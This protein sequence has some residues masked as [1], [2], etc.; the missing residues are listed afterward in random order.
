VLTKFGLREVAIKQFLEVLE[1]EVR[2]TQDSPVAEFES[3]LKKCLA[4]V[5]P[6]G[7]KDEALSERAR[8]IYDEIKELFTGDSL[9]DIGCGDG[10]ISVLA[11][12]HFRRTVATDVVDIVPTAF[13]NLGL[14]FKAYKEGSPLPTGDE[15][16]DTV[17]LL[18]VL[19]HSSRP[20]DLLELAWGATQKRLIIIESVIGVHE[21][22]SSVRYDLKSLPDSEQTGFAAFV[23]WFY[24]RVLYDDVP[25]PYN[26]TTPE[27]W[28]STF[29]E[30][31]M[32]K[33][34][35]KHFGQD[36]EIGPEYH[37]LFVLD[38]D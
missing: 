5:G 3:N 23:D 31:E 19:H 13:R 37:V 36:I 16:F 33:C 20:R 1:Q 18:T 7:T 17:L 32:H 9:L 12:Q 11:K 38:K 2:M 35:I 10:R 21:V 30:H 28:L 26:F 6:L 8:I 29:A 15:R 4:R 24:N 27:N 25:V 34:G 14:E 22:E